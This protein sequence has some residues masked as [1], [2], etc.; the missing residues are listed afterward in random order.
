MENEIKPKPTEAPAEIGTK[1]GRKAV[2]VYESPKLLV[3]L[4]RDTYHGQIRRYCLALSSMVIMA[5]ATSGL[6]L[7]IRQ[8]VNG[9]YF[10]EASMS[11]GMV[12]SIIVAL[13]VVKGVADYSQRVLMTTIGNQ[14]VARLQK[15]VFDKVLRLRLGY[16]GLHHSSM[17]TTVVTQNTLVARGALTA[18]A[19]TFGR[20]ALTVVGL[21]AVMCYQDPLLWIG[22]IAIA[23]P[24]IIGIQRIIRRI[25][26]ISS[27][28]FVGMADVLKATQ[29]TLQGVKTVKS[30]TMEQTMR[31]R[32][33]TSIDTLR[34]RSDEVVR[35]N[36]LTSP[37]METMGGLVVAIL[38]F[39]AGWQTVASGKTPG[40]F[41]SFLTAF[42]LAYEPAKRLANLHVTLQ[43]DLI[44]IGG[45]YRILD[46]NEDEPETGK[47]LAR[48]DLTGH[49]EFKNVSFG[50]N[51]TPVLNDISLEAKPGTI[52]ALVG[53]SGSGKTTICAL[54]E[55][56][57]EPWSGNITIDGKDFSTF[58]ITSLR[59]LIA[60]VGQDTVLFSGT[61]RENIRLGRTDATDEEVEAAAA[62]AA[63]D[64]ISGLP[65]G[66]ETLVGERGFS[67]SGGQAQRIAIARA[68]LKDAPI[69]ILDEATSAL[70]TETEMQVKQ[71][72]SRLMKG[73][74]TLVV[75]H[76]LSTIQGA[77][78]VYLM[79]AGRIIGEGSHSQMLT[80][81]PQYRKLF[82]EENDGDRE[83]AM[84]EFE[85]FS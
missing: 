43:R 62:A 50:Y 41:M 8:A 35:I 1:K 9:A 65:Q 10:N 31:Q 81:S 21:N 71:A 59:Q 85:V 22:A 18:A 72:L 51:S 48:E 23:P 68:I 24:V 16:L 56:F 67:M 66:F 15:R 39:Y 64:F 33:Q 44:G 45:V 11:T 27:R 80:K 26:D 40:E 7:L 25:R 29:E 37:L 69:L 58:E 76:R 19:T 20:D 49:I 54:L 28:E 5:A 14:V 84:A 3:R 75:A 30:F 46:L 42:L 73:R 47:V 55:R 2:S 52:V 83:A 13:S 53:P 12:A 77:D 74:T 79:T 38:V 63:A 17:L 34:M 36:S 82:G 61:V 32:F 6:A 60:S 4:F 70:D 57:Y 78:Y